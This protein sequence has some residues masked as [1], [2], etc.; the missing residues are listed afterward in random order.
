VAKTSVSGTAVLDHKMY[1]KR[2]KKPTTPN[3]IGYPTVTPSTPLTLN[4]IHD[5][6]HSGSVVVTVNILVVPQNVKI[7]DGKE[8]TKDTTISPTAATKDAP[9]TLG[10]YL[11]KFLTKVYNNKNMKQKIV[12]FSYVKECLVGSIPGLDISTGTYQPGKK[13]GG[14]ALYHGLGKVVLGNT[15]SDLRCIFVFPLSVHIC[16]NAFSPVH[17][18]HTHFHDTCEPW[19]FKN[20]CKRR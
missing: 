17:L 16:S 15:L 10:K 2:T 18:S 11:K 7:L 19:A 6:M 4:V 20:G 12:S 8:D 1:W 3:A 14:Y 13:M 9:S 5:C